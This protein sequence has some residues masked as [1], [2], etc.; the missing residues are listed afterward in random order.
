MSDIPFHRSIFARL[1]A[2]ALIVTVAATMA[3][4][5]VT[6]T[7]VERAST[8]ALFR[9]VDVELAGLADVYASAGK[10]ELERRITDRVALG[11]DRR[12]LAHYM[13]ADQTGKFITGN[14]QTWPNIS[15]GASQFGFVMLSDGTRV[16]ARA[17]K[18][19]PDLQLLVAREDVETLDLKRRVTLAFIGMGIMVVLAVALI[20]RAT[21]I[22]LSHRIERI[23]SAFRSPNDEA[24]D[25]LMRARDARDEIGE[26]TRHSA[27]TLTRLR[28]MVKVHRD[29]A[30][31]VAHELRTPLMHLDSRLVK[32]LGATQDESATSTFNTAREEIRGIVAM[33]E[34]LLDI[35]TSEVRRGDRQGLSPVDLSSLAKRI[36]EL[37]A[38][39]A[40]ESGHNFVRQIHPDVMLMGEAMQLTRLIT[41]LLDNAFKYAPA[42]STVTLSV[43]PG[44]VLTVADDG[45]GVPEVDRKRIFD[46]FQ[47]A[48]GPNS[49]RG[50][51]LGLALV[52]AIAER[53]GLTIRLAPSAKGA[54]FV[55]AV[56][57]TA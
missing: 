7:T 34:S 33:L 20:G 54:R 3:L 30:D 13:L 51:G 9:A 1:V 32:V 2:W 12:S 49:G 25:A 22:R 26:L 18:L 4:W 38:D 41:N 40:E 27:E 55:I 36:G 44:P 31:H 23:N 5:A 10:V 42:G 17:A 21:A 47:R 11:N 46:R 24:V 52:K 35:A 45:P 16:L 43:E 19:G 6:Q 48:R 56:E 53:H 50:S 57:E 28:R 8:N 15:A 39:S 37:Y 14:V 29:T